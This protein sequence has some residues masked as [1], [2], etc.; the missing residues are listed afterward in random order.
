L[1]KEIPCGCIV[2]LLIEEVEQIVSK[3]TGCGREDLGIEVVTLVFAQTE[4]LLAFFKADL[5]GPTFRVLFDDGRCME[6]G[7]GGKEGDPFGLFAF[8][9]SFDGIILWFVV[10]LC[11]YNDSF[12]IR[13]REFHRN[14]C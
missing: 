10:T 8:L 1:A 5:C 13:A 6:A 3:E 11:K 12:F 14:P 7:I 9:F 4:K 2:F